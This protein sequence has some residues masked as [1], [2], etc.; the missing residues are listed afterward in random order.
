[1]YMFRISTGQAILQLKQCAGDV[2]QP[3][4][5]EFTINSKNGS[6]L[7]SYIG[8]MT[9]HLHVLTHKRNISF[10]FILLPSFFGG[11]G[12]VSYSFFTKIHH[13]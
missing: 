12:L 8:D 5:R 11:P 13:K 6:Y 4:H 3:Q 2:T 1:M 7:Y 9:H 10:P